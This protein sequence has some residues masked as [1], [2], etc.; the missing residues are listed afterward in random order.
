MVVAAISIQSFLYVEHKADFDCIIAYKFY[1]PRDAVS[2]HGWHICGTN[3]HFI[4]PSS[5]RFIAKSQSLV[6]NT[7]PPRLS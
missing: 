2:F 6:E 7:G 1:G 5:V 3:S 4:V